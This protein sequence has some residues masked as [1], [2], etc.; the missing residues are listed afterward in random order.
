MNKPVCRKCGVELNDDSWNLS[1]I[2]VKAS[3]IH[4]DKYKNIY[5]RFFIKKNLIPDY[6]L[7]LA[8][9]NRVNLTPLYMWLLPS[10][11]VNFLTNT[12]ISKTM[13]NKWDEYKLEI[14]KVISCCNILKGAN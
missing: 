10:E 2:D 13:I 5:W 3:C 1:L 9:D 11:K 12:V 8:F 6:F 7:F 4:T 14:D